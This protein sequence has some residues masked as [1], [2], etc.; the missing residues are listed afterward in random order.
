MSQARRGRRYVL[1]SSLGVGGGTFFFFWLLIGSLI[2]DYESS[3]ADHWALGI[4]GGAALFA[5]G[6]TYGDLARDRSRGDER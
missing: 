2:Q 6:V 5:A 4:A 1:G 3:T